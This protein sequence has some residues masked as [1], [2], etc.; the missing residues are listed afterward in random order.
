[1]QDLDADLSRMFGH[2]FIK[3]PFFAQIGKP[4]RL[5]KITSALLSP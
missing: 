3:P 2:L 5:G 4:D 1:L